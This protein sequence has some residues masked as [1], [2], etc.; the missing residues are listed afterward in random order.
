MIT[1]IDKTDITSAQQFAD[2]MKV[3]KLSDGVKL[4]VRGESG[5][6]RMLYV[7]KN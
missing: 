4:T 7:Q 2:A 1:K 5:M 3:A 6:D